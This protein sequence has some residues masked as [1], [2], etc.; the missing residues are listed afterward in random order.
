M[1]STFLNCTNGTTSRKA[2]HIMTIR[3]WGKG[4]WFKTY[5][6]EKAQK[7]LLRKTHISVAVSVSGIIVALSHYSK[8]HFKKLF[9]AL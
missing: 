7:E 3:T 5:S 6:H 9:F 2:S 4:I 8:P 1:F